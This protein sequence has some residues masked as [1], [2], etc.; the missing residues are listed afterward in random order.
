MV[1]MTTTSKCLNIA[2]KIIWRKKKV[3]NV[4]FQHVHNAASRLL[5]VKMINT[6]IMI[7]S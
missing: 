6:K 2:M 4:G 5:I 7:K 1:M 3:M